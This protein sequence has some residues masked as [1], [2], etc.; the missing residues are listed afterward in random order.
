MPEWDTQGQVGRGVGR[1][2]PTTHGALNLARGVGGKSASGRKN[3]TGDS[4][5]VQAAGHTDRRGG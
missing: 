4:T 5:E 3:A 1:C 2:A